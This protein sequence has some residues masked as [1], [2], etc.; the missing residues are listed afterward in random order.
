MRGPWSL[1]P[2]ALWLLPSLL[3]LGTAVV[4]FYDRL[5]GTQSDR[6]SAVACNGNV[7]VAG[8]D[9]QGTATSLLGGQSVTAA[10]GYDC[11]VASYNTASPG[12]VNYLRS[13]G[14]ALTDSV[15]A[16]AM[17]NAKN[18]YV[19]GMT[20]GALTGTSNFGPANSADGFLVKYTSECL[21]PPLVGQHGIAN[22]FPLRL[23]A[24]IAQ[25]SVREFWF[26]WLT[27]VV[28]TRHVVSCRLWDTVLGPTD[29]QLGDRRVLWCGRRR[30]HWRRLRCR[31]HRCW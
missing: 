16:V 27:P 30:Q 10:G 20:Y 12:T 1:G 4:D 5:G 28:R 24:P 26:Y 13:F 22:R 25:S 29:R 11:L 23:S 14:G 6:V 3:G 18:A 19:T 7:C 21:P 17:D 2:R 31:L 8:G 15:A 9:Y